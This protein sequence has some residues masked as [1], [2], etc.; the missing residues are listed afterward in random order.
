LIG[1]I[2]ELPRSENPDLERELVDIDHFFIDP[3]LTVCIQQGRRTL[4]L[5]VR[6]IKPQNFTIWHPTPT[7]SQRSPTAKQIIEPLT[8]SASRLTSSLGK[9]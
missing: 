6:T 2:R 4:C 1:K 5:R 3:C 8:N 9:P 7:P